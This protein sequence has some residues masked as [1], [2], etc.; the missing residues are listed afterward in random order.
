M[1]LLHI[2]YDVVMGKTNKPIATLTKLGWVMLGGKIKK[3]RFN[4]SLNHTV[5]SNVEEIVEKF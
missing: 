4:V 2:N 3:D 1:P 5:T